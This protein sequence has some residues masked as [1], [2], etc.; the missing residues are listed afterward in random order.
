M[1]IHRL[2]PAILALTLLMQGCSP[3]EERRLTTDVRRELSHGRDAAQA[4]RR[5]DAANAGDSVVI[6]V[7]YLE[8]LRLGLGGPFR[9]I[10]TAMTDPRLSDTMRERVAWSLLAGVLDGHTYDVDATTLDRAGAAHLP[11]VIGIGDDHLEYIRQA[12]EAVDDVRG[13][14]LAVRLGYTIAASERSVSSEAPSIAA[15]VAALLADARIARNDAFT[16][17]QA[18]SDTERDALELLRE[19]RGDRRFESEQPKFAA[20]TPEAELAAIER[21]R[22]LVNKLRLVA[23]RVAA[24]SLSADGDGVDVHRSYLSERMAL[25]LRAIADS[26]NAPPSTPI[27]LSARQL[28]REAGEQ[29]WLDTEERI[30]RAAFS[31]RARNEESFA[32]ELALLKRESVHDSSP[33]YAALNSAVSLRTFAQEPVWHPGMGGPTVRDLKDR[34]GLASIEFDA[35]VPARWRPFLNRMLASSLEDLRRVLPNATLRGL[36]I[37]FGS[38]PSNSNVLAMHDPR[39]RE[40]ILP[41]ATAVGTLA[42][43]LAHDLDWQMSVGRY[44]VRGD[45]ASDRAVRLRDGVM[46][47]RLRQLTPAAMEGS[48]RPSAH[49]TRPAEVLARSVDWYVVVS[50]AQQGRSNGY[51]SSVIDEVLTG[52]GTV[53][54]P[55]VDGST[56]DALVALI[57]EVTPLYRDQR[58]AFLHA[59]GRAR[60][61]NSYDMVR[62]VVESVSLT[63]A[64]PAPAP[65]F[66]TYDSDLRRAGAVRDSALAD[67]DRWSCR[68]PAGLD[69]EL[70]RERRELIQLAANATVRGRMLGHARLTGGHRART[71]LARELYGGPWPRMDTDSVVGE[72]VAAMAAAVRS[73]EENVAQTK[74]SSFE[75]LAVG[76]CGLSPMMPGQTPGT[77]APQMTL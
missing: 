9:L 75:L 45:Y 17:L 77:F 35:A 66:P 4:W 47:A 11:V 34:Y 55:D 15:R 76:S 54:P 50:L 46:A 65:T 41:P 48:P 12:F 28:A 49:A 61:P 52:Y 37:R 62:K 29:P 21:A 32:A 43:E 36:R 30:T 60:M 31:V 71:T 69:T 13:A 74:T 58:I 68:M 64:T 1:R 57:G 5:A 8:R 39:K 67:I 63:P 40:L 20:V 16:L 51:L 19:W 22:T 73:F 42:H 33:A 38:A 70:D 23:A 27:V 10:E 26:F 72:Q 24:G 53:Q 14:E 6:A 25:R 59:Y 18:A 56:G 44:S 7:G 3:S 2:V